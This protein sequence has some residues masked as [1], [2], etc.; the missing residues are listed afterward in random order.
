MHTVFSRIAGRN[1]AKI[2]PAIE[3][4]LQRM[5]QRHIDLCN[6]LAGKRCTLFSK[7]LNNSLASKCGI[8]IFNLLV[9]A[10]ESAAQLSPKQL[11]QVNKELSSLQPVVDALRI[12]SQQRQEVRHDVL[13]VLQSLALHYTSSMWRLAAYLC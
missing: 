2:T 7:V 4:Q 11:G 3:V 5:R 13:S 8:V 1:N 9:I 10:A 12:L 6:Q